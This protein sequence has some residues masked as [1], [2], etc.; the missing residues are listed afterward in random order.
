MDR[1]M[2]RGHNRS[3]AA[4]LLPGSNMPAVVRV[5]PVRI[6]QPARSV[7]QSGPGRHDWVMEFERSSPLFRDSIM[8]WIG[9][10]DPFSQ[11]QLSFPDLQSAIEFADRHGWRYRVEEPHARRISSK[12][13]TDRFKYELAD[14]I[15]RVAYREPLLAQ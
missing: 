4:P 1:P 7:M 12:A 13:Y 2:D 6:Y 5:P 10:A 3:T 8:G 11:I 15:R 9:D 14:A